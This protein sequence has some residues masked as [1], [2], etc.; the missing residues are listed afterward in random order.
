[1]KRSVALIISVLFQPLVVPVL[2]F[3]FVFFQVPEASSIPQVL[4]EKLFYLIAVM[5]L[6]IP[7]LTIIGLRLSGML[8]SLHMANLKDRAIPFTI[9]CIYYIITAYF[10]RQRTEFDPVLWQV[11]ALIT[12]AIVG[13][14][15]ITFFWK[16]SAH[17]TGMG[18]L[19]AAVVVLGLK[20]PN[21]QVLYP[22]L[23]SLILTGIVA[24][25]RLYL[26]AHKP[27]EVYVGL[28]FGFLLCFYGFYWIWS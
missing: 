1:M 16:M 8:K 20:F 7:M 17:M 27:L 15:L 12:L 11:L 4:K 3:W 18:G 21:F 14:T 24:T 2:V 22:L 10:I 23:G 28:L 26:H 19:I 6:A 13:L 5:T 25:A 9:T